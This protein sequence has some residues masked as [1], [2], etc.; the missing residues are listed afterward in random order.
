MQSAL[1]VGSGWDADTEPVAKVIPSAIAPSAIKNR[2][3]MCSLFHLSTDMSY[4]AY[5]VMRKKYGIGSI[6]SPANARPGHDTQA[7][8]LAPVGAG[9]DASRGPRRSRAWLPRD[10]ALGEDAPH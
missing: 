8:C 4:P 7:H 5:L 6:K 1:V 10:V 3:F 9:N 2:F